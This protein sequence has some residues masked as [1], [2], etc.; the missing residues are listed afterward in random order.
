MIRSSSPSS[1]I[2]VPDHLPNS[3][4]V[5]GL[6]IDRDRLARLVASAGSDRDHF[7]LQWLL[8]WRCREW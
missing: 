1:L 4:F 6:D 2:L 5:A 8:P 7:A 3:T